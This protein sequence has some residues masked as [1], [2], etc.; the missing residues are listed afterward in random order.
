LPPSAADGDSRTVSIVESEPATIA[1][2]L[3]AVPD[4]LGWR[5]PLPPG[6]VGRPRLVRPLAAAPDAGVAVVVAP[7]GY[8]KT[9]L[10]RQ[11]EETDPRPFEWVDP[12]DAAQL[13]APSSPSVRVLDDLHLHGPG[14]LRDVAR[15]VR[16]PA[17]GCLLV[18]ASRTAPRLPVGRLRAEGAL[19]E[20]GTAQL[21]MT[22][23]EAA[24]VLRQAGLV[25]GPDVIATLT[26]RAEGWPAGLVLAAR[27]LRE[28]RDIGAAAARFAG[29]DRLVADYL[30]EEVLSHLS[31]EE[32]DFVAL[33]SPLGDLSGPLC[34]AVLERHGCGRVLCDLARSGLLLAPLDPCDERFRYHP[35][36]ADMLRSELRRADPERELEVHRRAGVWHEQQGRRPGARARDRGRSARPRGRAHVGA[37]RS[38]CGRRARRAHRALAGTLPRRADRRPCDAGA[39][40]GN[41]RRAGGPP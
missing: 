38:A 39:D 12:A 27:S 35:L 32:L 14:T 1:L 22:E 24:R 40:G 25:A 5:R 26:R 18:L 30:R 34:D 21:A 17:P 6:L 37:G 16:R 20:L 2:A 41:R 31:L 9:T 33:T 15:L 7:A 13:D 23:P 29:D 10:L 8:G 36:L 28:E 3:H 19:V 4:E 11:W